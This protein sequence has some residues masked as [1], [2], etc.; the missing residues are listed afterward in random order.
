MEEELLNEAMKSTKETVSR[1]EKMIFENHW[2]KNKIASSM[3]IDF[4]SSGKYSILKNLEDYK[5]DLATGGVLY[6]FALTEVSNGYWIGTDDISLIILSDHANLFHELNKRKNYTLGEEEGGW[7]GMQYAM[8][9]IAASDWDGLRST[10]EYLKGVTPPYDKLFHDIEIY[11]QLYNGF[12]E[13]DKQMIEDALNALE[14]EE[15]RK[16]RQK[17]LTIEKDVSI[18]TLALGRLA[19]MHGMEV[20]IDSEYVPKELLPFEP[21]EEYTIPYKFL[22][23]FYRKQGVDWRYDPVHPELQDWDIDPENPNR[24][25]DGFFKRLFN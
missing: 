4:L 14:S 7:C 8:L 12:L 13:K 5:S 17:L 19:W 1:R 24:K 2:N 25:K 22:R 18:I 23:D 16:V 3:K 11:F 20:E 10:I 21:L 15:Y 6:D 9:Q